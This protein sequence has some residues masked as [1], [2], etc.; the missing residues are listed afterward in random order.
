[1]GSADSG[2]ERRR[3]AQR[4]EGESI[5]P[6]K[7]LGPLA[8]WGCFL[9]QIQD[10]KGQACLEATNRQRVAVYPT[11]LWGA[12]PAESAEEGDVSE[13]LAWLTLQI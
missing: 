13:S 8:E 5:F 4:R 11:D 3:M 10:L 9:F 12:A 1:M 2:L 6:E 7:I